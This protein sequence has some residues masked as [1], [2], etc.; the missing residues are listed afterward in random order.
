MSEATVE[1]EGGIV[2][3][4]YLPPP[5]ADATLDAMNY[6]I[7]K[8][9]NARGNGREQHW[10]LL[11]MDGMLSR[12]F[13]PR[14]GVG[15]LAA[16]Q[17]APWCTALVEALEAEFDACLVMPEMFKAWLALEAGAGRTGPARPCCSAP[18]HP[19]PQPPLN[20]WWRS[21]MPEHQASRSREFIRP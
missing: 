21:A 14:G 19:P 11:V 20:V 4:H 18:T 5:P 12:V 2:L 13:R 3:V 7:S 17:L 9:H 10:E 15:T 6:I 16:Q 8:G 1:I